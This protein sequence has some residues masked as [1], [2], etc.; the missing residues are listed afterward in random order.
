M[1]LANTYKLLYDSSATKTQV[2]AGD[3]SY[4]QHIR[5]T[6]ETVGNRIEKLTDEDQYRSMQSRFG[7]LKEVWSR[8]DRRRTGDDHQSHS[9]QVRVMVQ[10]S[11]RP[12]LSNWGMWGSD[13]GSHVP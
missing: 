1:L 12:L 11:Q 7:A 6:H 10:M 5:E 3:L 9:C 4:L 2:E 13:A 8:A